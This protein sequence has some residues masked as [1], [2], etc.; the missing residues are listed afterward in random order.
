[1]IFDLDGTLVDSEG[2][3]N[4][5]FLDLLPELSDPVEALTERYR[6]MKLDLILDDLAARLGRPLSA[7][8]ETLYRARVSALCQESLRPFAGVEQMLSALRYAKC[9]ASSGP[10]AKIKESLA[11]CRI[12]EY[13]GDRVFSSYV[14]KS[15]KPDPG[16]FM[17]AARAMGFAPQRCV[18]V[19]DSVV[20]IEAALAAEM[21]A[22]HFVPRGESNSHKGA[23]G[24]RAMVQ[25]PDLLER[26]ARNL[27]LRAS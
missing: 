20:G 4:Q 12:A 5:A 8:F 26:Q 14:V 2:L 15:W 13:F 24:F 9:V 16:L 21:A 27:R 1:M 18:V 25:L 19:E 11:L 10:P 7:G 23:T 6:G 17:H 22:L 3:C